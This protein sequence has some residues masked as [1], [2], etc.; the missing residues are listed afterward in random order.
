MLDLAAL[1]GDEENV[2]NAATAIDIFFKAVLKSDEEYKRFDR[3]CKDPDVMINVE[4]LFDIVQWLMET[5][6]ER[7]TQRSEDSQTGQ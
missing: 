4:T 6:G 7:P 3:L 2:A 1:S 5:Y